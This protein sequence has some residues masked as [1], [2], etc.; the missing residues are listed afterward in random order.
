M[1]FVVLFRIRAANHAPHRRS[2]YE[3]EDGSGMRLFTSAGVVEASGSESVIW[4]GIGTGTRMR[5]GMRM[6][7]GMRMGTGMRMRMRILF[8]YGG[9]AG[10]TSICVPN[11]CFGKIET[12]R[13]L[14]ITNAY[15]DIQQPR[16]IA[17]SSC[18]PSVAA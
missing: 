17:L 7:T 11:Y 18:I 4:T 9:D 13:N 6:K 3:T 14:S 8:E 1:A 5:T 10:W 12:K 2:K 16:T 15:S